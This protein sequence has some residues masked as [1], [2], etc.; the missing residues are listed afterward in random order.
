MRI[1]LKKTRFFNVGFFFDLRRKIA[2]NAKKNA[3]FRVFLQKTACAIGS[4]KKDGHEKTAL[5]HAEDSENG[6]GYVLFNSTPFLDTLYYIL[7][8]N[9]KTYSLFQNTVFR[10][11]K[12]YLCTAN[13]RIFT[14]LKN[15]SP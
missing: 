11:F 6:G 10:T 3:V 2:Q 14:A 4:S 9:K 5:H 15:G 7:T 1:F 8:L 12:G 13:V